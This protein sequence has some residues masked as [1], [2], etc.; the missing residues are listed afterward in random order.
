MYSNII[1][2]C[3]DFCISSHIQP[4]NTK[5][6]EYHFTSAYY[7]KIC[8]SFIKTTNKD[9][10]CYIYFPKNYLALDNTEKFL[11]KYMK[12]ISHL[13]GDVEYIGLFNIKDLFDKYKPVITSD[14]ITASTYTT[15]D[16]LLKLE[17]QYKNNIKSSINPNFNI[18]DSEDK[19][20]S[21][22]IKESCLNFLKTESVDYYVF[23]I[24]NKINSLYTYYNMCLVRFIF[25]E[26]YAPLIYNML[27]VKQK[28]KNFN[29]TTCL[30]IA[31]YSYQLRSE[32]NPVN[33]HNMYTQ[34]FYYYGL[35]PNNKNVYKLI[36]KED[37]LNLVKS[38][39][40]ITLNV[41]F[42]SDIIHNVSIKDLNKY[43]KEGNYKKIYNAIK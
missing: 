6:G 16:N 10:D 13:G 38:S 37:L 23:K 18:T 29:Y 19:T 33:W 24:N 25:S 5:F 42:T 15:Y 20:L 11:N 41:I 22:P 35:Y 43:F 1:Q 28:C 12:I 27:K 14:F 7:N 9:N 30:Q 4:N 2:L 32:F 17:N 34:Y 21:I 40:F 26:H 31:R 39:K 3:R 8:G 36:K